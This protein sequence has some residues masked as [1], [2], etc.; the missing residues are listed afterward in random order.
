MPKSH[1][2]K[3]E[4]GAP[5]RAD[6][7]ACGLMFKR[8]LDLEFGQLPAEYQA[9]PYWMK[10]NEDGTVSMSLATAECLLRQVV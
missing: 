4:S 7:D 3:T 2:F 6:A 5:A 1:I 9:G 8:L 10:M